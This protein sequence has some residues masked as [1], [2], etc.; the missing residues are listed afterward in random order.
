MRRK[1]KVGLTLVYTS[2]FLL[3]ASTGALRLQAAESEQYCPQE[4]VAEV[5]PVVADIFLYLGN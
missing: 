1:I 5:M 2:V 3:I 4:I